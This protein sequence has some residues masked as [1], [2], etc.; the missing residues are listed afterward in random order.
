MNEGLVQGYSYWCVSDVFEELGMH[1]LPFNNE[2]GLVNVYGTRKPVYRLFEALHD[3]GGERLAIEG[4]GASRTAEV[5]ALSDGG[6][7]TLFAY[8]HDIEM[9]D[10]KEEEVELTLKG[11]VKSITKAAIDSKNANPCGCWEAMGK[12]AYPTKAQLAEIENAS[13]LVWENVPV[14]DGDNCLKF[15]LEPESVVIIKAVLA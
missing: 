13:S 10:I 2:F 11:A 3:A 15:T 5:L 7:V 14:K 1:G 12:P 9:R 4:E 6:T 8:N